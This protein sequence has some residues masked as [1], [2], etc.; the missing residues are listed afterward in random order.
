MKASLKVIFTGAL[1]ASCDAS[2]PLIEIKEHGSSILS[3][4]AFSAYREKKL[5]GFNVSLGSLGQPSYLFGPTGHWMIVFSP[6]L[7]QDNDSLD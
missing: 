4:I 1:S 5:E 3:T 2:C 6:K 7:E